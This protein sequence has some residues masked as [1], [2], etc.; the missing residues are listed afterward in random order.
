M[1]HAPPPDKNDLFLGKGEMAAHMRDL[2]WRPT[3]LGA[4]ET[5]S[6]SLRSTVRLLLTS[7]YAMWMGWGPD[8]T[9]FYNDAYS[10]TLGV[11][12]PWALSQPAREVWKE[13]WGDIGPLID[14][15][16]STG[17]AIFSNGL[18]LFLERSGFPEETYH[19]FSYSP[20][21]DDDGAVSGMLCVVV[22]ETDR[23]LNERR[24][25][26]LRELATAASAVTSE[27]DLFAVVETTLG[28]N[29]KDLPFTLTYLN[30][31]EGARL[32]AVSGIA[33]DHAAAPARIEAGDTLHW[34]LHEVS[35]G[36]PMRVDRLGE[37]FG[38]MP[39]GDWDKPPVEAVIVPMGQA[40]EK[41]P[42]G[43]FI[44]GFNPYRRDDEHLTGFINLLAGQIASA[45]A[46]VRAYEEEKKRAEALAEIDR[47]KTA[48]F[49]NVSHEFRTPLTL[50]LGPLE[51][52]LAEAGEGAA[53]DQV[54]L[55]HRNGMRL[56][57]L[58]NSL[59]DFSRIEA[60]RVQAT[61]APTDLARFSAEIASSF[62]SAVEKAGLVLRID[63]EPIAQPVYLDHDMW[64]KVLLNLLSNA[65]KFTFEGEI[66]LTVRPGADGKSAVVEVADTG[67]GVSEDELPRL[68]ERFHRIEGAQ[69]RS[70]EGSGIGLALVQ[71]LVGLHGGEISARSRPG[72][73]TVFSIVLPLGTA[74]V[75]ADR[76]REGRSAMTAAKAN[77]FV[78]EA[79]RWIRDDS[80]VARSGAGLAGD[81][82]TND[83]TG[84]GAGRTVIL[85]DDNA[86]MRD[87]VR[88]LLEGKG[89]RVLAFDNGQDAF[90]AARSA[91]PD[92]VLSDVMMPRLDGFGLLRALRSEDALA[93]TPVI[94][95]S[96]RAGEE[97]K[98]EGLDAGA[99]D[100]LVKP[101][102]ARELLARVNANIQMAAVRRDAERRIIASEQKYRMT[103]ERLDIALSTGQVSVFDWDVDSDIAYVHGP[104][105]QLFG[106][107]TGEAERGVPLQAFLDG[108]EPEDLGG[109][110]DAMG[111][112][113]ETGEPYQAQYR[114]RGNGEARIIVA[115][116]QVEPLDGG[117]KRLSGT[118]IDLTR[119]KAAE[120][121]LRQKQA[122]LEEQTRALEVLNRAASVISGNLDVEQVVQAITDAGVEVSG[123]QFGAFFYNLQNTEG[124]WYTLYTLSGAERSAFDHFPMPRITGLFLPT[125]SGEGN[126][127]SDDITRDARYGKNGPHSGMPKGHLPVRSYLAV[128]V[129]S[130]DGAVLGGLF[131][132][133]AE[134]AVFTQRDEDLVSGLASQAAV[135][136]DNAQLF[137]S[138]EREIAQRMKA[139]AELHALNSDLEARVEREIAERLR[140]EDALRQAQ[141]MEAVGQLTGG[142]AHD[143]NNLLTV[144]IG[145]LDTIK[146]AKPEDTARVMRAADMALQGAQRAANLT[147]R[148][149]AFSRRQ[150]LA[151][152]PLE[153]NVLVRDMTELLH[154]T[155]GE[156]IELEGVLAPRLWAVEA[157]QN[158]L[159]SAIINM[160]V[161]ARDAMPEGGKLT[162]ETGNTAL[163]EG[164]AAVDSEVIPGQYVVIA[165]SDTGHGMDKETLTR[166]FE[167]FFT[168]KEVGR[169]TGLGLSQVYG[170]V[171]QS[172]GHITVYSEPGQG[173][174][175][176]MY[177]PRYHGSADGVAETVE[178]FVPASSDGEVILL[179]EDNDDV[180]AYSAMILGELGYK[181]LEAPEAGAALN[182]LRTPQRI[183]LLFTDVVLPG[184]SGRVLADEAA[185]LRPGLKILFT[186]GYSR[187]AI[188]HHGRLDPGVQL[189]TKPFT[190]EQLGTRVRDV[191]DQS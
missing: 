93:G 152:K 7:S 95:L 113:V 79:L 57:R 119:E 115:R 20:L 26:T 24:L 126:V 138:A 76:V 163:D 62:R 107:A 172:G 124:E 167:P 145:G 59:L 106:I 161:N 116:G 70:F 109:M 181:V 51:E 39:T 154:R 97:A 171:K 15:V 31:A 5:W 132:G 170:F 52:V 55:A 89:Y 37:R 165:V 157:D 173:T 75:P 19:T 11:K 117:N 143:F 191:L 129:K 40:A 49:S 158:Q 134:P 156:H 42:L 1:A 179:V 13:I 136:I 47:A 177:F 182:I 151:P 54:E 64:E 168:T 92:L 91:R 103:R 184:R 45:L 29:L 4:P 127:R 72:Q 186:T 86:D 150:P 90:D 81:Q 65:F 18:L 96:A 160:A 17:E 142:V 108:I 36:Q 183:D 128:P 53:R 105:S 110:L 43:Y 28:K 99:D 149:L 56:L 159:E 162:I 3:P 21:F 94:L 85:A 146:R 69:G 174:T 68:F 169:G 46:G 188:M 35:S 67:I 135:A 148:L 175:V 133:H 187:N 66:A 147:G 140:V 104:L 190:F 61:Y 16:L 120:Q 131:F 25:D 125:F 153:L 9:F 122:E 121:A 88:R 130:R 63:A 178:A 10:P 6:H 111:A 123:A 189:I 30:E 155:L 80:D 48:F 164:Y 176:K 185:R 14:Q 71:E 112:S 27:A 74:H 32:V 41:G 166:V 180:R 83:D 73:G 114:T 118:L 12:H 22:E 34:P 77:P 50:M 33:R 137:Q 58:V 82:A 144:I 44:V 60:G 87:Y 98:V 84:V 2:D 78:E 101:F 23:V 8:L 139:E 38:A 100:Y 141:K 102:A